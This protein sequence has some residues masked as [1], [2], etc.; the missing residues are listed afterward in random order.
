M[1]KF[2]FTVVQPASISN[3]GLLDIE[4]ETKEEA[5]R[6]LKE[7]LDAECEL[8]EIDED[9]TFRFDYDTYED[10]GD[11]EFYDYETGELI[12][13]TNDNDSRD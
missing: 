4:A 5:V 3:V 9:F 6:I 12:D 11:M 2:R 7:K 1:E 8:E 13:V 10:E